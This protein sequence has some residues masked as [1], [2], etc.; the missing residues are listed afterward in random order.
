MP[1]SL[2]NFVLVFDSEGQDDDRPAHLRLTLTRTGAH[3]D[4]LKEVDFSDDNRTEWVV[5]NKSSL[6]RIKP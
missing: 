4:T 6:A 2:D 3:Y 5:R 1:S